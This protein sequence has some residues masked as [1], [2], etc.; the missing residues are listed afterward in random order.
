MQLTLENIKKKY[1]FKKRRKKESFKTFYN[2]LIII[3]K[4]K[5]YFHKS[6]HEGWIEWDA[7]ELFQLC[8]D[9]MRKAIE[10]S[11][12]SPKDIAS[13]GIATQRGSFTCWDKR[14]GKPL[15]CIF[16]IFIYYYL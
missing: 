13:I 11:K 3:N 2:S 14:N 16:I 8:V 9:V 12:V 1:F 4:N 5:Q 7:E 15:V 10:N 6:P